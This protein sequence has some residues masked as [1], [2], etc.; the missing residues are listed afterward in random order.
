MQTWL[1][2][3]APLAS[4]FPYHLQTRLCFLAQNAEPVD[5]TNRNS[6]IITK[7]LKGQ[8]KKCEKFGVQETGRKC[9]K[10]APSNHAPREVMASGSSFLDFAILQIKI[11]PSNHLISAFFALE[12]TKRKKRKVQETAR[13]SAKVQPICAMQPSAV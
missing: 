7:L 9:T 13:N 8:I 6:Q 1:L 3:R 5:Q 12:S 11:A 4:R 10:C 2:F